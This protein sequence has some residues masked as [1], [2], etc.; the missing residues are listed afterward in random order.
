VLSA[1]ALEIV[2][3]TEADIPY[4]MATER[5][6]GYEAFI[7]QWDH[8]QHAQALAD[9]RHAYFLGRR[10]GTPVGFVMVRDYA[11][12]HRV[13]YIKRVAVSEAGQGIGRELVAG[14]VDTIFDQTDAYRVW[15]NTLTINEPAKRAYLAIG[16]QQEGVARCSSLFRG[17]Y[18]DELMMSVLRPEWR[19]PQR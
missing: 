16:F 15:L 11:A 7:G 9:G 18:R 3:A 1:P 8:E 12:K 13:T 17:E 10:A 4:V 5:T 19:R 14:V 2:R 6:P